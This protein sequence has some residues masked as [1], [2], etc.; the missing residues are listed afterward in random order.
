MIFKL[1]KI[2]PIDIFFIVLFFSLSTFILLESYILGFYISPDSSNYLLA[3]QS[4]LD[5]NG[6]WYLRNA[7][8]DDA[9]F[10]VWPIG[11]P[12][13]I[14][15]ISFLTGLEVYLASKILTIITI[16]L[17][18][19]TIRFLLEEISLFLALILLN[20]GFLLIILFT[21]TEL[22][23]ILL[24]IWL[25]ILLIKIRNQNR[26]KFILYIF[27]IS[28]SVGMFL[29]RYIGAYSIGIIIIFL[30][31]Q[32]L[33][34]KQD[35]GFLKRKILYLL[36]SILLSSLIM[37]GYLLKNLHYSGYMTGYER[38]PPYESLFQLLTMLAV[39]LGREVVNLFI[40]FDTL[41]GLRFLLA[42]GA[43][44]F[45]ISIKLIKQ[46]STLIIKSLK[47]FNNFND[48][49]IFIEDNFNPILFILS[50]FVYYFA[51]SIMRFT[52][53]FDSLNY[54]LL[55][56][57]TILIFI[58]AVDFLNIKKTYIRRVLQNFS[59]QK[60]ILIGLF[61]FV[62]LNSVSLAR[63]TQNI[64]YG[65]EITGFRYERNRVTEKFNHLTSNQIIIT[66]DRNLRFIRTDLLVQN[67]TGVSV[68]EFVIRVRQQSNADIL[69]DVQSL[70]QIR[71]RIQVSRSHHES[72]VL[73]FDRL[74]LSEEDFVNLELIYEEFVD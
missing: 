43:I 12:F 31:Y 7:G 50:G 61:F 25:I 29:F 47:T 68:E 54:R 34:K 69:I 60:A 42:I 13:M 37:S 46:S 73:L 18:I 16:L 14:F 1:N 74:K 30:L 71:E 53:H 11:Y 28:V 48:L 64:L 3:A 9:Y 66:E 5:G 8:F 21:W 57:G 23:F 70:P 4:L 22:I 19:I 56:P 55:F 67:P 49:N 33:G 26:P 52:A 24:N 27:L 51:I 45:I 63:L 35:N 40:V 32:T 62:F 6:F 36:V 41:N 59:F 10:A 15:F 58:G 72:F 65:Q 17:L 38:R 44:M 39:G 2:N 20:P